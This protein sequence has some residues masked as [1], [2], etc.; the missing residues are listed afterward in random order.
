MKLWS[1][2]LGLAVALVLTV[3]LTAEEKKADD[4]KADKKEVT[5]KGTMV[6]GKCTLKMF[7]ECT[8]VVQVKEKVGDKEETV[9]YIIVDKGNKADY[10]KGIC[11]KDAKKE[12]VVTGTVEE[13]DKKKFITPTKVEVK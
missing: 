8:N 13:K 11:P 5:I 7:D 12:V 9:N 6:C 3:G 4:K 1:M 2:L 10:H